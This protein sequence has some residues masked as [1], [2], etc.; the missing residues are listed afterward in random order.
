MLLR[1]IPAASAGDQG[2]IHQARVASRRLRAAL[3]VLG[4]RADA[5]ALGRLRRQVRRITRALGPV[6]ELDVALARLEDF[7]PRA[8]VSPRALARV[9][10]AL[11]AERQARRREMLD[12]VTPIALEK[13]RKRLTGVAQIP[14]NRV[15]PQD[16][17]DEAARRVARRAATL[18]EAIEH[19]GGIYL[20]DRLHRV[21]VA[22]KKLRYALEIDRELRRSRSAARINRLKSLQD[23]LG[24]MHDL[25]I[26]IDRVRRVQGSLAERERTTALALD[27][28]IRAMEQDCRADHAAY[29]RERPSL[30]KLCQALRHPHRGHPTAAA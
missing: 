25:E 1:A 20:P 12:A 11:V 5:S 14:P 19:A 29:M 30:Q 21:R 18:V 4:V 24:R 27:A 23:R 26:L 15:V 13:L 2:S 9:R 28:L 22:A 3:P 7:A 8:L 6:R 16:E 10:Q 17:L